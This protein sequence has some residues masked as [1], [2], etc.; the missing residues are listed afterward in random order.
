MKKYYH[1]LKQKLEFPIDAKVMPRES[2]KILK[3][4]DKVKIIGI[5]YEDDLY[6][7]ICNIKLRRKKHT[8]PLVELEIDKKNPAYRII[9]SYQIHFDNR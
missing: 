4:G 2:H 9:K 1:I 8:I 5:Q 6:G 3:H 7:V